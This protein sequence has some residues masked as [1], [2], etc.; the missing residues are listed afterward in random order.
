[1]VLTCALAACAAPQVTS[2]P[3]PLPKAPTPV[4]PTYRVETGQV[5]KRIQFPARV[6]PKDSA[7]LYFETDGRILSVGFKE[8]DGVKQGDVLAGL[9]VADLRNELDQR[10]WGQRRRKRHRASSAA[11]CPAPTKIVEI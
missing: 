2:T 6:Q 7:Q 3:T 8:G 5:I 10:V 11:R 9:D 4:P 1:M